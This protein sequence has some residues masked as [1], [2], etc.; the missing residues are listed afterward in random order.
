MILRSRHPC[1]HCHSPLSVEHPPGGFFLYC[2]NGPC[3]SVVANIGAAG[4]TED[5]AFG[6]LEDLVEQEGLEPA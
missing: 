1:P 6:K 2:G 4:K 3:R 5:E